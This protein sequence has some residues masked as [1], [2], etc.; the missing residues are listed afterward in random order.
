MRT[1]RADIATRGWSFRHA[2]SRSGERSTTLTSTFTGAFK[3]SPEE[4]IRFMTM[5][6]AG[7][8]G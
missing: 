6:R 8:T 2:L 1:H 3:D 5:I 7:R 4:Q